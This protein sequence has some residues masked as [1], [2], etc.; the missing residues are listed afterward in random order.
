MDDAPVALCVRWLRGVSEW[1]GGPARTESVFDFADRSFQDEGK[2]MSEPKSKS[3]R[4]YD[5]EFKEN[6][7]A[8]VIS[9]FKKVTPLRDGFPTCA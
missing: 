4:R 7:V 1:P 8:L 6:A 5:R 3:G 2:A 9:L